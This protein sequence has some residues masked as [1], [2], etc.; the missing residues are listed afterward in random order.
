MHN[1]KYQNRILLAMSAFPA[2][3]GY[4][5]Y[6]IIQLWGQSEFLFLEFLQ[7]QFKGSLASIL[8]ESILIKICNKSGSEAKWSLESPGS[9]YH[10]W[11][12]L[13]ATAGQLQVDFAETTETVN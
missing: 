9:S 7:F 12:M 2:E 11:K 8:I 13:L 10:S 1:L 3:L 4:N 5:I 6:S